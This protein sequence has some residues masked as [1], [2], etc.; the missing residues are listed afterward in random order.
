MIYWAKAV[1]DAISKNNLTGLF[2]VLNKQMTD[3]TKLIRRR[4]KFL[5]F[6]AISYLIVLNVHAYDVVEICLKVK[7]IQ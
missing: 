4:T 1:E 3:V 7:M 6:R 5:E 2:D